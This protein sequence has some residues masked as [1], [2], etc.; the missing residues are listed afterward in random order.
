MSS[1]VSNCLWKNQAATEWLYKRMD[2]TRSWSTWSRYHKNRIEF[3]MK[4]TALSGK[5]KSFMIPSSLVAGICEIEEA[6]KK[7]KSARYT[8][9]VRKALAYLGLTFTNTNHF[10]K[11]R[12][13]SKKVRESRRSYLMRKTSNTAEFFELAARLYDKIPISKRHPLQIKPIYL[14]VK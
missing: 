12:K 7:K 5:R 11:S 1:K 10:M 14:K 6:I 2:L 13:L 9:E 3:C 4:A 8:L